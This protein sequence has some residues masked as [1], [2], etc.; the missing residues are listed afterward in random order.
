MLLL[1][2]MRGNEA[3]Y[4]ILS[5]QG[6]SDENELAND[7]MTS[8]DLVDL[9]SSQLENCDSRSSPQRR[10]SRKHIQLKRKTAAQR[11]LLNRFFQYKQSDWTREEMTNLALS[12]RLSFGVV[13]KWLWDR[14]EKYQRYIASKA[15][16]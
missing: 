3:T 5:E 7:Q 16:H 14:R 8:G 15:K 1:D 6:D 2:F 9:T 4:Q 12:T 11:Q 13:R 10:K